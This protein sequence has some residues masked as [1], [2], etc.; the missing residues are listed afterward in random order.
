L[1]PVKEITLYD[2]T[3][4]SVV[5][6]NI[7]NIFWRVV[8]EVELRVSHLLGRCSTTSAM[9]PALFALVISE[10]GSHFVPRSD[11]TVI[12]LFMI[13]GVAGMTGACHHIQP[14]VEMK[15]QTF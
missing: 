11:C 8:L 13:P 5:L 9:P 2:I 6:F 1:F 10:I 12:L 7:F 15:S 4:Y 3:I 14:L